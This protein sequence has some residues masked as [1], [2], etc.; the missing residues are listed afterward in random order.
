MC[1][2]ASAI[3]ATLNLAAAPPPSPPSPPGSSSSSPSSSSGSVLYFTYD[4]AAFKLNNQECTG[5]LKSHG[6]W[7]RVVMGTA[8]G[9]VTRPRVH[10]DERKGPS[11]VLS[12]HSRSGRGPPTSRGKPRA[13]EKEREP[14]SR[15]HDAAPFLS[16][17]PPL[18]SDGTEI[19]QGRFHQL[20]KFRQQSL[21]ELDWLRCEPIFVSS[22]DRDTML[23]AYLTHVC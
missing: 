21:W 16:P 20:L 13:R 9:G 3:A 12:G 4:G 7:A 10:P 11:N 1:G 15:S 2:D 18:F 8:N 6:A 5:T 17:F 14:R 19:R 23:L 22:L